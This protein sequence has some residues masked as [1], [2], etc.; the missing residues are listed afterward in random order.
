M[1]K[2]TE[3]LAYAKLKEHKKSL[4]NVR[5]SKLFELDPKRIDDFTFE[6]NDFLFDFS[7]NL[8]NRQTL[9]LL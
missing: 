2:L 4:D 9:N 7:K 6:F 5:I 3:T 8:I 1:A